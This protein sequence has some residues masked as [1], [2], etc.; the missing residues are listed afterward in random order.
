MANNTA[1]IGLVQCDEM[2]LEPIGRRCGYM[3]GV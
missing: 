1:W 3:G 2:V